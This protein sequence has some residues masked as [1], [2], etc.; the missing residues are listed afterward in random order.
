M[1]AAAAAAAR[2]SLWKRRI[3][4]HSR[5]LHI[6]I[7]MVSCAV[8][9][10][11]SLT[12]VTLN[13]TDL[14]AGTETTETATGVIYTRW[15]NTGDK[16]VAKL[17]IA[18]W[19]RERHRLSGAVSDFR[20]DEAQASI[21]FKGP[22]YSADVFVDRASGNYELTETR[23]G[24]VAV[25]NDL[26]KGRDS[27][28]VWKGLIDASAIFLIFVALTGLVLLYFVQKHRAAGFILLAFGAALAYVLYAVW[29]P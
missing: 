2:R 21:A 27:G 16:A 3:A 9:L 19:L 28:A 24:L 25:A 11:F 1:T 26:H 15:T 13:H 8:V 7:S 12:G 4:K 10:F 6:Y 29:V 20:V 18:E 5:W 14:L 17:E 22:G 23:L